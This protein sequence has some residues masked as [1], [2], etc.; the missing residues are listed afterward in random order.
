MDLV[1]EH[2]GAGIGFELLD[3]LLEPLLEVAAVARA[4]QQRAHVEREYGGVLEHVGN[5]A[6][7]DPPRQAFRDRSLSH[8]GIADEQRVVL[9]PPAEDLDGAVDLGIAADQRID[10]SL[11]G[12]LVEIHA[13][14]IEG[15]ALLLGVIAR[16]GVGLVLRTPYWTGLGHA[17][18]LGDAVTDVVH[19]IVA[20]HVLLLQEVG[21]MALALG[22]D[23]D[24]H[25]GP[26]HLLAAGRLHVYD[27]PLDDT[28]E[29]GRGLGILVGIVHE[30]L[31]LAFEVGSKA[32]PQLVEINVACPHDRRRILVVQQRQQQMLEGGVFVMT[33]VRERQCAVQ[34][35]FEIA[36]KRWHVRFR[37]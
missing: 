35:L 10:L 15:I 18:A 3:H 7:H 5:F 28:L 19:R 2:D 21:G 11:A 25:V 22:K 29:A 4:G 33:L 12:F 26:G 16:L 20:R 36:R 37:S 17:G 32:A 23:G 30:V 14:G 13:V 8:A 6:V 27:C 9:L 34:G 31:K 24:E 1:D